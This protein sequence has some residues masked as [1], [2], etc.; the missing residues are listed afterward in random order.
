[1]SLF[2][3]HLDDSELVELI[4]NDHSN[5]LTFDEFSK[6]KLNLKSINDSHTLE[7]LDPDLNI[8]NGFLNPKTDYYMQ[9]E[10]QDLIKFNSSYIILLYNI[11]SI[12]NNLEKFLLFT[13]I[14]SYKSTADI[15][16]FCETKLSKDIEHL[17]S[18]DG[19]NMF[20]NSRNH[21]GGGVCIYIKK[22]IFCN[23]LNDLSLMTDYI[24]SLFIDAVYRNKSV[25]I[26]VIYRRP[27]ASL[28]TFL[29]LFENL[30]S[31]VNSFSKPCILMGDF[32]VNI[33]H[34]SDK[35]VKLYIDLLI[36]YGYYPCIDK[37]TRVCNKS[38]TI[39]DHIWTNSLDIVSSG[40]ILLTDVSDHFAPFLITEDKS[41]I[42]NEVSFTYRNYNS[43]NKE[44][45]CQTMQDYI[46]ALNI[47][48]NNPDHAYNLVIDAVTRTIDEIIPL[49][50]VRIKSKQVNKPWVTL[51]LR[52]LIKERHRLYKK[53]LRKPITFGTQYKELRDRV[54]NKLKES[55]RLHYEQEFSAC[56]G[57]G[58][59]TWKL[60][61]KI[62]NGK[63]SLSTTDY[64]NTSDSQITEPKLISAYLNSHFS[65]I[66]HKLAISLPASNVSPMSYL[67]RNYPDFLPSDTS[68]EEVSTIIKSL[69]DSAPGMD[70]I[71]IKVLKLTVSVI[72]PV[73]SNLINMSFR[74]GIFPT[75]LKVAKI[76]PIFKGGNR[77]DVSNYRPIS[78]LNC[79]S[80]LYERAMSDRLM[81]S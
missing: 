66:G 49:K 79:I 5:S 70:G 20:A 74:T 65:S 10:F 68:S 40:G 9:S 72:A 2:F 45:L 6:L 64:I 78:I 47:D 69:K 29:Q 1:M 28:S 42:S 33:L 31:R 37:P 81:F 38:A 16:C 58:K 23:T 73:I 14:N 4:G 52:E 7:N 25:F 46:G 63:S 61:N 62:I 32:N 56:A 26:G 53:Y 17:Y 15:M 35:N 41:R 12:P 18:L 51:E 22:G 60:I 48:D 76:V 44:D 67:S 39:I 24:E 27:N 43:V 30:L 77:G 19:Y 36:S 55:K 80:K 57:N 34:S 75:K 21:Y 50:T 59:A 54:N 8:F 11:N 13:E 3:P 71:H